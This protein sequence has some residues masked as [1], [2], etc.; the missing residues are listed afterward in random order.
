MIEA[1]T[2]TAMM[3][4]HSF[5]IK[6]T[7]L[8]RSVFIALSGGLL[9]HSPKP[10]TQLHLS[11]NQHIIKSEPELFPVF[12]AFFLKMGSLASAPWVVFL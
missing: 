9:Q 2:I 7:T 11:I 1:I 12:G 4:N 5:L 6:A 10:H 8:V 3:R